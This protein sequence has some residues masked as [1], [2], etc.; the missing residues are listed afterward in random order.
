VTTHSA[1]L[2]D[3]AYWRSGRCRSCSI[4]ETPY[5]RQLAEKDRSARTRV[6]QIPSGAWRP[7][8]PSAPEHFRN[9]AKL[10]VG[11]R[12][13]AVTVGILDDRRHGVDLRDCPLHEHGLRAAIHAVADVVDSLD[14]IP[15]DV[16]ARRGELK[17]VL[18]T[19][20]PDGELML[21]FVLRSR[22][23]LARI[24]D[25][26]DGIGVMLPA[27]RVVSVNLH[28]EHKAVLEGDEETV[29]TDEATLPMRVNDVTLQLGVRSFFQTNTAVAAALYR[30]AR[31][32][33][34]Q[35]DIGT[36]GDLF[37]G[38]GGFAH[39]L[40]APGRRVTGVEISAEAVGAARL[41]SGTPPPAFL[42]ADATAFLR[43]CPPPDLVVVNPPRRG[44]T[45]LAVDL[46]RSG[47]RHLLYSSCSPASLAVDLAA[48]PS[49][50][51]VR[52]RLFDMFPQTGHSEILVLLTRTGAG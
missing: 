41:G 21:R 52:A 10:V 5:P 32:W 35:L 37:C 39:H 25:N 51:P 8:H 24:R 14:L 13:G 38:V 17:Y 9:K 40:T 29:L 26:L 33:S 15:Y 43:D 2:L 18:L 36:V 31:Q 16:P 12:P 4:I 7:A 30:T 44:I 11:G 46:E 28:P 20:S 22:R 45:T 3:C 48:M 1:D 23:H 49:L 42:C 6:P 50:R 19:W 34:A 27:A 47:V